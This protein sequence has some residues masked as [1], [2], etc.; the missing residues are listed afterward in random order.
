MRRPLIC[1]D[2]RAE[3]WARCVLAYGTAWNNCSDSMNSTH[4]AC[5]CGGRPRLHMTKSTRSDSKRHILKMRSNISVARS[6]TPSCMKTVW[7]RQRLQLAVQHKT[8]CMCSGACGG[9]DLLHRLQRAI[10]SGVVVPVLRLSR[11][12]MLTLA[13]DD[14]N[15]RVRIFHCMQPSRSNVH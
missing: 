9:H 11:V 14:D 6:T 4:I 1:F 12:R 8:T 15:S 5:T 2:W 3:C 10:V 13:T 7:R